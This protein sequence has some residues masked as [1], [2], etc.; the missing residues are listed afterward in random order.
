[1]NKAFTVT[2]YSDPGHGWA[3]VKRQVLVNLGID[4]EIRHYSYQYKDNVYL[5]EDVDLSILY[6]RMMQDDVA[7]KFEEK[8]NNNTSRIR[9]YD[10]YRP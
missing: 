1:M 6:R 9:S 10:S 2:M 4:K 7:M 3:K 8:H 5:E